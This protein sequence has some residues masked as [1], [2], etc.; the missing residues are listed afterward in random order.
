MVQYQKYIY[1]PRHKGEANT[2]DKKIRFL[3]NAVYYGVVPLLLLYFLGG[4]FN[5]YRIS[6]VIMAAFGVIIVAGVAIGTIYARKNKDFKY[7]V[8][9]AYNKI[10]SVLIVIEFMYSFSK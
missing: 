2:M 1:K 4:D 6:P 7:E 8:N 10:I 3:N 9:S 5:L